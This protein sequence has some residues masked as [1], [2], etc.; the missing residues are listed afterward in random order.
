MPNLQWKSFVGFDFAV[1]SF[2]LMSEQPE[3]YICQGKNIL[4]EKYLSIKCLNGFDNFYSMGSSSRL[5]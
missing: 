5:Y 4:G 2:Y 1:L 3:L